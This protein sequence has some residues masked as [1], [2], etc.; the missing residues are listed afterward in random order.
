MELYDPGVGVD[1]EQ[2]PQGGQVARRLEHPAPAALA[3]TERLQGAAVP[4]VGGTVVGPGQ[5]PAVA[6]H[7]VGAGPVVGQE[8]GHGQEDALG[9][10]VAAVV[11]HGLVLGLHVVPERHHRVDASSRRRHRLGVAGGGRHGAVNLPGGRGGVGRVEGQQLV[12]DGRARPGRPDHY[13]GSVDR[14]LADVGPA[15]PQIDELQPV[16][17]RGQEVGA[18]EEP[19]GEVKFALSFQRLHKGLEMGPPAVAAVAAVAAFAGPSEVVQPGALGGCRDQLVRLERH[20]QP[21][22]A[23]VVG[24]AVEP[25]HPARPCRGLPVHWS[26]PPTPRPD[27]RRNRR[28]TPRRRAAITLRRSS[29]VTVGWSAG[30]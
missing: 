15:P 6:G 26:R 7:G 13:Q 20:K 27:Q 19:A 30:R 11:V 28:C 4:L 3:Q 12:Q 29:G 18:G 5:M 2:L 25:V 9:G 16:A 10:E 22:M 24:V 21:G 17:Q 23:G 1:R 8:G 14:L